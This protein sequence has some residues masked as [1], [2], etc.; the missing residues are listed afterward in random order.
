[1]DG[2]SLLILF[3]HGAAPDARL[4]DAQGIVHGVLLRCL[5]FLV[6]CPPYV[7][8][9]LLTAGLLRG[10][11]GADAIRSF[12]GRGMRS[13]LLRGWLAGFLLP[14]C[15]LGV[16]PVA[17]ELLRAGAP[18]SAVIAFLVSGACLNP[19]SIIMGL[20]RIEGSV[21]LFFVVG[22]FLISMLAG[23]VSGDSDAPREGLPSAEIAASATARLLIAGIHLARDLTGPMLRDLSIAMAGVAILAAASPHGSLEEM[24]ALGSPASWL[25]GVLA[26][27]LAYLNPFEAMGTAGTLL[28]DGFPVG[29]AW[30]V[31]LLGGGLNLGLI[32]WTVHVLGLRRAG[33]LGAAVFG[34]TIALALGTDLITGGTIGKSEAHHTHAFDQWGRA[35]TGS[36]G[37]GG[38]F[39]LLKDKLEAHEAIALGILIA[40]GIAGVIIHRL[41]DRASI[42]SILASQSPAPIS[43]KS[44]GKFWSRPLPTRRLKQAMIAI[45]L[46][47][48]VILAYEFYPDPEAIFVDIQ[49]VRADTQDAVRRGSKPEALREI[50]R[51]ILLVRKLPIGE[52]LRHGW[53]DP[54]QR[55][56]TEEMA[57]GLGILRDSVEAGRWE[58]ARTMLAYVQQIH[59]ECRKSYR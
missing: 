49:V 9:G 50:D 5:Q 2:F 48:G 37:L 58:E 39:P 8:L 42:A 41:G 24:L 33:R 52:S 43:S 11:V 1:M 26:C 59:Q 14:T 15:S 30:L 13:G 53:I 3:A 54:A 7:L 19:L 10:M 55:R 27:T 32:A 12:F 22:S 6:H 57:Y 56:D 38:I 34:S 31:I 44:D 45:G 35:P 20:T 29:S 17:R 36:S 16:L 28:T 46:A 4:L 25:A 21:L 51:W 18:R 40:A 23:A 47:L